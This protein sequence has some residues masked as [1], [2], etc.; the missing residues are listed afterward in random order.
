[1]V[2]AAIDWE[3][4]NG[5]RYGGLAREL[6]ERIFSRRRQL[7]GLEAWGTP[8]STS[9][10]SQ[11]DPLLQGVTPFSL[12]PQ[13][14]LER[15]LNGA[16]VLVGRPAYKEWAWGLKAGW[17]STLPPSRQDLDEGLAR[18]LS[19]DSV[20]DEAEEITQPESALG[21]D[22]IAEADGAGAPLP[23]RLPS[24]SLQSYN[25]A[26]QM[27]NSTRSSQARPSKSS[28]ETGP[29]VDPKVLE[30]PSQIPAQP[31][32]CFVDFTI[33]TGIK[34]VP[35]KIYGFFNEREKVRHGAQAALT[36][37]LGDKMNAREFEFDTTGD[38]TISSKT[39]PQGGDLDWGL[40]SESFYHKRFYKTVADVDSARKS[41]YENLPKRLSDTRSYVRG[42]RELTVTE[43]NDP[44][45]SEG[46]LREERFEREKEWRNL[47]MGYQILKRESGVEWDPAFR[48]S[49]RVLVDRSEEA[50]NDG[51]RRK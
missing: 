14:Q 51:P 12:Q 3:T 20:F 39:P 41:F 10:I 9:S 26:F 21:Q 32:L 47:V 13:E 29:K 15:E 4:L 40:G 34:H 45:K 5:T 8:P 50:E 49:L 19:E 22:D 28:E 17:T 6:R 33:L 25:P 44:P 37:A 7:L 23:S 30:P 43:K 16:V 2:A 38:G 24:S 11:P 1:M 31:P 36:I 48:G 18:E 46:K 35:R 27:G 42:Q